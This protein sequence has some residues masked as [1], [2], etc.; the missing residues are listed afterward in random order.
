MWD[1]SGLGV[2]SGAG[3]GDGAAG[4]RSEVKGDFGL[5]VFILANNRSASA[6]SILGLNIIKGVYGVRTQ[7]KKE[8]GNYRR[9][10]HSEN[11]GRQIN[12]L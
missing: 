8:N 12:P 3:R 4:L 7:G 10:R 2:P 9:C 5:P 1:W 6:S 11:N